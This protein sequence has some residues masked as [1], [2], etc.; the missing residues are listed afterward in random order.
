MGEQKGKER[1]KSEQGGF[2]PHSPPKLLF[3]SL[4]KKMS[5]LSQPF[6]CRK[7]KR[8]KRSRRRRKSA[9]GEEQGGTRKH[10]LR[11]LSH[12]PSP[13]RRLR[14]P[15]KSA[16]FRD[17]RKNEE[18]SPS[19]KERA[20]K[21]R[22]RRRKKANF[23]FC[24]R[25]LPLSSFYSSGARSVKAAFRLL[26]GL[27]LGS[28]GF[29]MGAVALLVLFFLLTTMALGLGG[30]RGEAAAAAAVFGG[31]PVPIKDK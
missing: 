31:R 24:S 1:E 8:K 22:E 13:C 20:K 19:C 25:S 17:L 28:W 6:S 3:F 12:Y 30:R 18:G 11:A 27:L 4:S 9:P 15:P 23:F 16:L 21:K 29:L 2:S 7:R 10:T 5:K 26:L 14:N